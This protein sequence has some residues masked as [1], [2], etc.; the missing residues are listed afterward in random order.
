MQC[1][2][3]FC[4]LLICTAEQSPAP[5]CTVRSEDYCF[6]ECDRLKKGDKGRRERTPKR[7]EGEKGVVWTTPFAFC[8]ES[9]LFSLLF[10]YKRRP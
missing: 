7:E 3:Q 2:L 1:V 9:L 5:N 4:Q 6:A 8:R 10:P